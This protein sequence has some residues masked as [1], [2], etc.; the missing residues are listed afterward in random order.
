MTSLL[1]SGDSELVRLELTLN[2]Y[3]RLFNLGYLKVFARS[4]FL[5]G[6]CTLGCLCIAY[7]F[8]YIVARLSPRYKGSLILLIMIPFWTSSLIRSYAMAAILKTHGILNSLLLHFGIIAHPLQI[9]YTNTATVIGLI[10]TLLPLMILPIYSNIEKMDL[11]LIDAARD[12]GANKYQILKHVLLP[13]TFPGILAGSVL[14]FLPAMTIFYVPD[15]LGG[16][17]TILIG[18]LIQNKFLAGR[19]WPMGA[20]MSVMLTLLMS[21]LLLLYWHYYPRQQESLHEPH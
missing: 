7:P 2:N 1:T 19:D 4:I 17:R 8:S 15:L 13:L 12:L 5:A 9:L 10:Y 16:A 21:L 6:I 11:R 14:V 18:N 20:T 3:F